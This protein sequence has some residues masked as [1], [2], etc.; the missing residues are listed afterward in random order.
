[1]MN[2][3]FYERNI[4]SAAAKASGKSYVDVHEQSLKMK[5]GGLSLKVN[6]QKCGISQHYFSKYRINKKNNSEYS[7]I[8]T[9]GSPIVLFT[10]GHSFYEKCLKI[11]T[12]DNEPITHSR[13]KS[14]FSTSS[15]MSGNSVESSEDYL[16]PTC[17]SN[18]TKQ[19]ILPSKRTFGKKGKKRKRIDST[20]SRSSKNSDMVVAEKSRQ[21]EESAALQA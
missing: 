16:C 20:S 2:S 4:M 10:C 6:G 13:R 5:S 21:E 19:D 8:N 11:W 9:E 3:K 17:L 12:A 15:T 7:N 18:V 1:M 14:S